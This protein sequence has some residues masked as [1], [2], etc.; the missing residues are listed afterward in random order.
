M[1]YALSIMGFVITTFIYA[2]FWHLIVF[3]KVYDDIGIYDREKQII[4]IGV[5]TVFIQGFVFVYP[6]ANFD[7]GQ[8]SI[9]RGTILGLLLRMF[10]YSAGSLAFSAKRKIKK[11]N[12]T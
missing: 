3:K 5:L 12:T 2:F 4:P 6:Y 10:E 1:N 8:L 9:L 7:F 11:L